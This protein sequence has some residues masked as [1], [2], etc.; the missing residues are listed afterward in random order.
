MNMSEK[1]VLLVDDEKDFL[2]VMSQRIKVW[3][4]EVVPTLSAREAIETVR[5]DGADII[6]MDYMMPEM[7]GITAA[8]KIRTLNQD[9]PIIMFTAHP[10]YRAL[11]GAEQLGVI[12]F[13]PKFSSYADA[14][15]A[16]QSALGI[17]D[18]K[19]KS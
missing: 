16:L 15:S 11:E 3:G 18:K 6:V 1:R 17:A 14:Q 10:D 8:N 7:D 5:A 12:A 4:Y 19:L 9:I 2:D 13:I